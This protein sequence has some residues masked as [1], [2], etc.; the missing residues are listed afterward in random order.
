MGVFDRERPYAVLDPQVRKGRPSGNVER[1]EDG[2]E[3]YEQAT[4]FH[5]GSFSILPKLS[6]FI[7]L[8]GKNDYFRGRILRYFCTM[9]LDGRR[10]ST[11]VEDRR[12]RTVATAGGIGLGGLIIAGL[13]TLLLGGD[14]TDVIRMAGQRQQTTTTSQ[15]YS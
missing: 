13:I 11:N 10:E 1:Q 8:F 3:Q 9:R 5:I 12:G 6:N 2:G 15:E 4:G 14:P 7:L